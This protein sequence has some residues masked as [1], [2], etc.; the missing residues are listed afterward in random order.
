MSRADI[1]AGR[2]FVSLYVKQD[3]LTRGLTQAKANVSR[4]GS[5]MMAM[6]AKVAGFGGLMISPI[7]ASV[8]VAANFEEAISKFNFV[9]KEAKDSAKT[10]ADGFAKDVGRS[11]L[12]IVEFMAD[13]QALVMPIGF[14]DDQAVQMS[15]QLTTLAV[16]LAS[17]NNMAD[18]DVL[19][20]LHAALVGSSET[21]LKYGVIANEAAVKQEL[22]NMAIKPDDATNQDKVLAR[23][24]LILRGTVA[25]QG[26]ATRTSNSLTNMMKALR[27][28]VSDVAVEVGSAVI[29]AFSQIAKSFVEIIRPMAEMARQNPELVMSFVTVSGAVAAAGVSIMG[30]GVA[31]KIAASAIAV[32][33]VTYKV[34]AITASV[35]WAGV[36][37]AFSVLTIK[38][39]ISAA[40]AS[41]AW[42]VASGVI[43]SSWKI[44]GTVLSASVSTAVLVGSATVITGAWLAAA[45]AISVAIFG[46][47]TVLTTTATVATAAWTAAGGFVTTAW[48]A[49]AGVIGT[50]WTAV[51]GTVAALAG[52][53]MG[54]WIS[55]AGIAGT[56]MAVLGAAFAAAGGTGAI[57]AAITGAAWSAAGAAA[58]LAWSAFTA[59]IGTVFTASNLLVF[60]AFAVKT[61]WIAAWA[62]VSGPIL[63][64][65]AGLTLVAATIGS[66]AAASA[67]AAVR[68]ADFGASW[69]AVTTVLTELMSIAKRVGGILMTALGQGDFDIAFKAAIA[70]VKLALAKT[71]DGMSVL[72]SEF[73]K[74]AWSMTQTFFR[75]FVELSV[76]VLTEFA[77]AIANPLKGI[78]ISD[79]KNMVSDL[80]VSFSFDTKGMADAASA[81]LAKLEKELA[82]RQAKRTAE[83]EA[84]AKAESD[85]I[86]NEAAGG[87][88]DGTPSGT[89]TQEQTDAAETA[90]EAAKAFDRE[91]EALQQQIIALRQ[92]AEAAERFRLAKQGLT[93]DQINQVMALRSEQEAITK[94]QSESERIV[95]RIQDY[96]DAD[97]EKSNSLTIAETEAKKKGMLSAEQQA[98]IDKRKLTPAQI[99]EK[100]K[101]AIELNRTSGRI[102]SKTAAEAMAQADIRQA[103]K[104]HQERLKK[105]K[106][107]GSTDGSVNGMG[108]GLKSGGASAATFS[109]QSLIAMGGGSGQSPQV[110]ALLET[111]KLIAD[112]LKAQKEQ[113]DAQIAAINKQGLHHT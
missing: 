28:S 59:V 97:Y 22:L 10:W 18:A 104:E 111:K 41:T 4:F 99:A 70:G 47:G 113:S 51:S 75:K 80:G 16:D 89:A 61:A 21:M 69:A 68:V 17:F 30:L 102:D 26:D 77:E 6:G 84:K 88:G 9:F 66:I 67:Y 52:V 87:I 42:S 11:R 49:T 108:I 50:A 37:L 46:L 85:R 79:L 65:V 81:E 64:I 12:Q 101:A 20:D 13:S 72:W 95:S 3:Q 27:G 60:A 56:A 34:A 7:T 100:E 92:G 57:S 96:A 62:V 63:P 48:V 14:K 58:S 94:Q 90:T 93:E 33:S 24:N 53:A 98:E 107:D 44:L 109:A 106:D 32:A 19:R 82:D 78:K 74:Q 45:G 86:A 40:I 15:K 110:R 43:A 8:K 38:A 54:A 73:W 23:Y 1:M 25:A 76:K 105:F 83:N 31:A 112:Q 39:K 35:A 36:G 29:P 91:T 5:D 103:E 71:L 55:G 2:A